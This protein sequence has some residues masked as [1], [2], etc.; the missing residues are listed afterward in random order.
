MCTTLSGLEL[1]I[2][3]IEGIRFYTNA[4]LLSRAFSSLDEQVKYLN[5]FTPE[6]VWRW[7]P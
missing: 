7:N 5:T 4:H 6:S 3:P 1:Q 2:F